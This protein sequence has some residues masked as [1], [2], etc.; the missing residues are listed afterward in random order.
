M[1]TSSAFA[2]PRSRR[3]VRFSVLSL[4]ERSYSLGR[5]G[6]TVRAG[7]ISFCE[8]SQWVS[9]AAMSTFSSV[10]YPPLFFCYFNH[11]PPGQSATGRAQRPL[12]LWEITGS[13]LLCTMCNDSL[14]LCKLRQ[15]SLRYVLYFRL[16]YL[17]PTQGVHLW[18]ADQISKSQ[19]HVHSQQHSLCLYFDFTVTFYFQVRILSAQ[20]EGETDFSHQNS[21][22]Q[23]YSASCFLFTFCGRTLFPNVYSGELFSCAHHCQTVSLWRKKSITM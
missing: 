19:L 15:G 8:D 22:D 5:V 7:Q 23:D 1:F 18:D 3:R 14:W 21:C 2:V 16:L 17:W 10:L 4:R 12:S 13:L 11:I 6:T 20:S 9:C